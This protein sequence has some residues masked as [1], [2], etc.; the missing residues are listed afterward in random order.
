[1]V[2]SVK[3][4]REKALDAAFDDL[5]R[6]GEISMRKVGEAA[7]VTGAALY[8][9]F[10]SKQGL[11]DAIAERVASRLQDQLGQARSRPWLLVAEARGNLDAAL[12]ALADFR[13][14]LPRI[15]GVALAHEARD[16]FEERDA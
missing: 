11:L 1:M 2:N 14:G 4:S 5:N 12:T 6:A 9:H 16:E 8:Y 13:A 7:G 3:S 15:D 10:E